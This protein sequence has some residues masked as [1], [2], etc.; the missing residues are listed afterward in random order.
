MKKK[1]LFKVLVI[2]SGGREHAIAWSLAKDKRVSTV[3]VAPGNG[4]TFHEPKIENINLTNFDELSNF[5]FKNNVR[6]T[7]VGPEGPL[8]EGLVDKFAEKQL[9]IF[10]PTREAAQLE[11]SKEFAKLFMQRYK[12]PSAKF[13]SFSDPSLAHEYVNATADGPVV[14]KADGLAAGKGVVIARDSREAHSAIDMMLIDKKMGAAGNKI[15]IEEFL[16]GEELSFIVATDGKH[17][18]PL[19]TSRDHKRLLENDL[20]PN[21]GGMGAY[22][23]ATDHSESA[24]QQQ[25]MSAIIEPTLAGL[26]AEKILYKGF[27]YAGLMITEKKIPYVLEFNCRLGDP[28]TQPILFRLKSSLFAL[29]EYAVHQELDKYQIEWDSRSALGTVIATQGY[30][31]SPINGQKIENLPSNKPDMHIF[32]AGTIEKDGHLFVN[33]GR[34]LCVTA[35]SENISTARN[36]VMETINAI[37]IPGAQFRNDIGL[38]KK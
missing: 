13:K 32:H 19:A 10:G 4:G 27:L 34:I 16:Q 2:G 21:T 31:Q 35:L 23:P 14:V 37:D 9:P 36:Q 12:I 5:A 22:S 25:I 30:P 28:E 1:E 17:I 29:C 6:L 11:S 24:L 3:Y 18:V 33:G 8:S 15:I 20:G 38:S 7:V 26:R